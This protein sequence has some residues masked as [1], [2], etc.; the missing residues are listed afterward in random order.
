[1]I[2]T[3]QLQITFDHEAIANDFVILEAKRDSGD[4]RNSLVPDLALQV[5]CAL[6]VVYTYGDCCYILYDRKKA[7]RNRLKAALEGEADD[8]RLREVPSTA[9]VPKHAYLLAQLLCN[10]LP[11]LGADGK[12]YHNLTGKL[13]R[14]DSSWRRGRREVLLVGPADSTDLGQLR[15]AFRGDIPPGRP[16]KNQAG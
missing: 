4:Y 8:I 16:Q 7:D 15:Q 5:G 6:A 2:P 3:N 11:A 10:A 13:Y 14:W 12:M 1:M 9:F